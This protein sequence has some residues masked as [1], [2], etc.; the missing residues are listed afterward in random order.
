M[1]R[2]EESRSGCAGNDLRDGKRA[3]RRFPEPTELRKKL[4]EALF[5]LGVAHVE[6]C[7]FDGRMTHKDARQLKSSVAGD[8]NHGELFG[9]SHFKSDGSPATRFSFAGIHEIFCPA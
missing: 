6:D 8:T 7:R 9:L 2:G 4:S 1:G 5:A 3:E